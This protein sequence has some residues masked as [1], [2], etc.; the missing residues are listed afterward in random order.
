MWLR[1]LCLTAFSATAF[2]L[3]ACG[4][5]TGIE[6]LLGGNVVTRIVTTGT[7]ID[8]DG[9]LLIY[10]GHTDTA[11]RFPVNA[12]TGCTCGIDGDPLSLEL[13]DVAENCLVRDENPRVVTIPPPGEESE[14][15]FNVECFSALD[16]PAA[17]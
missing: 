17:K 6:P 10:D 8:P 11:Q 1:A 13:A 16:E 2:F 12:V 4:G 3:P 15:T 9:Y 5:S 14:T 7:E